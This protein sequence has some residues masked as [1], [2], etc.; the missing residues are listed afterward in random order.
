M[1]RS[2]AQTDVAR[3]NRREHH[4]AEMAFQFLIDLVG[5]LQTGIVHCQK[6]TFD[7]QSGIKARLYDA[8]SVDELSD[9]LQCEIFSLHGD[10]DRVGR[11]QGIDGYQSERRRA[12]DQ[13]IIIVRCYGA[14]ELGKNFLPVRPAY[15]FDLGSGKVDPRS[16]QIEPLHASGHLRTGQRIIVDQTL[17]DR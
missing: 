1:R 9:P 7:L 3:N 2:L 15:Q 10:Y 13:D 8:D 4:I 6:E 16:D 14:K 12:V 5:E 17:I 11:R